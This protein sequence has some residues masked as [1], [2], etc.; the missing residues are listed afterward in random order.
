MPNLI[1]QDVFRFQNG[2]TVLACSSDQERLGSLP[3][4]V[5]VLIADVPAGTLRLSAQRMPGPAS[6]DNPNQIAV[7]TPD[8]VTWEP[9]LVEA[10]L[11]RLQW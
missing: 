9:K 1:V 11:V 8:A 6:A 3:T 10:G 2:P 5:S 4:D 7:E